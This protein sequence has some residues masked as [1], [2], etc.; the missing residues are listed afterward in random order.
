MFSTFRESIAKS[1]GQQDQFGNPELGSSILPYGS[2]YFVASLFAFLVLYRIAPIEGKTLAKYTFLFFGVFGSL[3]ILIDM[4]KCGEF[5]YW[6]CWESAL[7]EY[8][9]LFGIVIGCAV[10]FFVQPRPTQKEISR[11]LPM[12]EKLDTLDSDI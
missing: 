10:S 12:Q 9:A 7:F 2:V 6:F 3:P 1:L 11:Y 4:I 8:N 5:S